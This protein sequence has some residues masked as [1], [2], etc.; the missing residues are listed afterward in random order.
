MKYCRYPRHVIKSCKVCGKAFMSKIKNH[1]T[2]IPIRGVNCI[3]CSHGC[4]KE[5]NRMKR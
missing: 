1:Y 2:P 4:S 5:L 3:T